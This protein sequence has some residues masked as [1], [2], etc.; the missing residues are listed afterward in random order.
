MTTYRCPVC[1]STVSRENMVVEHEK[2]TEILTIRATKTTKREW[3]QFLA[4]NG[5]KNAE[6]G[7]RFA[8]Q[9]RQADFAVTIKGTDV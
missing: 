7:L 5:L 9:K 2:K 1:G 6:D 8:I 3:E 4:E